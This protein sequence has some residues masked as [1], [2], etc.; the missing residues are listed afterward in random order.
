M[1][2]RTYPRNMCTKPSQDTYHVLQA[3]ILVPDTGDGSIRIPSRINLKKAF[4]LLSNH[5]SNFEKQLEASL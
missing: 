3:E 4:F 5:T 1:L 2:R